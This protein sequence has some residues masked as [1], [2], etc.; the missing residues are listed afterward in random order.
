MKNSVKRLRFVYMDYINV[1][2]ELKQRKTVLNG[3]SATGKSYLYN[4]IEQYA[5]EENRKDIICL[6]TDNVD[7]NNIQYTIDKIQELNDGIVIIDQADNI[8]CNKI[9]NNFVCL[10]N[11]N[12]YIIMS[13][14]Y[15]DKYSELA[16][17]QIS[18]KSISIQYKLN[19]I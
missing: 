15:Y 14:K 4:I 13:R 8:L 9:L 2:I 10:D 16:K 1:D 3:K 19:T 17:V 5:Q 18:K 7:M 6:N 12:Y 11:N